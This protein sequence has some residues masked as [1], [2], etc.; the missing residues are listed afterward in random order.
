MSSA[1]PRRVKVP[2]LFA[3]G[4]LA[5]VSSSATAGS[6]VD[7]TKNKNATGLSSISADFGGTAFVG[8][9]YSLPSG[10]VASSPFLNLTNKPGST[11]ESAYNT[12]GGAGLYLSGSQS[13]SNTYLRLRDL[14]T[15]S[16]GG[17]NYY[18]FMLQANEPGAGKN[19]LSIDN[20]RI[21]TSATD[22]TSLVKN[23]ETKLD[24]LGTKRFAL[25]EPLL[26]KKAYDNKNWI[27]LDASHSNVMGKM[28]DMLLYVPV[29][30]F[31]GAMGSDFVWFYNL[32][33]LRS[34]A[35]GAIGTSSGAEQWRAV[36]RLN[37]FVTV[38]EGGSTAVLLVAAV[39]ALSLAARRQRSH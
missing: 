4:L 12:N 37:G 30:A 26:G 32:N 29:S 33:G 31:A 9:F 7:L 27:T 38:P 22:N 25:N 19:L 3:L 5:A 36:T 1:K 13:G 14:A 10:T 11:V 20:I 39:S 24:L 34:G 17:T 28:A 15:I 8:N 2:P 23:D 35:D 6:H 18:A 21:Y 16:V